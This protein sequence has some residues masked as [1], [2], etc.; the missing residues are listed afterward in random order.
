MKKQVLF[1][2]SALFICFAAGALFTVLYIT[3]TTSTLNR[4]ITLHQAELLREGLVINI[5]TVQS[6]LYTLH[7][8]LGRKPDSIK[9]NVEKL[10]NAARGCSSCHHRPELSGRIGAVQKLI[11]EYKDLL[12]YYIT[13]SADMER[14]DKI[15]MDTATLG[16]TLLGLTQ[17]MTFTATKHLQEE[18]AS[19]LAKMENARMILFGTLF[20]TFLLGIWVSVHLTKA[21]TL[22][23]RELVDSARIIASGQL[24]YKTAYN[25]TSEFGELART[26]NAMSERLKDE[27]EHL[28]QSTK[29]AAIGELASNVAHEIN[30]PLTSIIGF[31]ELIRDETNLN[32][33]R[34]KLSIIE[35]ESMRA[36]YIVRELL[37]FARKR[38]LEI[39]EIDINEAIRDIRPLIE[40][41]VK[42]NRVTLNETYGELPG[43]KGDPNQLKQVFINLVNNAISAMP[44][45]GTLGIVTSSDGDDVMVRIKDTGQG[46]P[47]RIRAR[48]FEPFFS[49]KKDKGTGLG[50]PIS[51]R[52][53][54]DH[55]GRIDVESREGQGSTFT[56]YLPIKDSS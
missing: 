3:H 52:I 16:N 5:Q 36:R 49:T 37:R 14:L 29:L 1:F 17:E 28:I 56:V 26:F 24:G 7:T 23:V 48:I 46:I 25:D 32:I 40:A 53:I 18:T 39:V 42:A 12:N 9:K 19:A 41:Q 38:P 35:K 44:D 4:L 34:D 50:L 10:D 27:Q 54:Q 8:L 15:K 22:P 45:G 21:I 51:F 55:G 2:L 43:I 6:D 47:E 20:L 33:I 30:T 11:A 13:A 31:T